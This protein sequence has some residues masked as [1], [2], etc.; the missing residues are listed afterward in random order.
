MNVVAPSPAVARPDHV[1]ESV[2]FDFDL[3]DDA[4]LIADPHQRL[5]EL[6]E[7]A[8]PIF[9]T[10]RRGG[11]WILLGYD[12]NF[13]AARD[14]EVFSSEMI[15][16]SVVSELLA[17][18][19]PGSPR[20]PQAFPINIDPPEHAKYRQPLQGVFSPRTVNAL[21]SEIRELAAELI[22]QFAGNGHC[23]FMSAVAEPLPVRV[24]LNM[25]GLPV[26]QM[27]EYRALVQEQ[28]LLSPDDPECFVTVLKI[29]DTMRDTIAER[30]V[31]PRDDLLSLL[32]KVEI[33]GKPVTQDDVENYG[34]LLFIA[35]LDTVINAIGY[36]IRHLACD[37]ALQ[38]ALREDTSL[39]PIVV[40]EVLRRYAFVNPIRRVNRDTVFQGIPMKEGDHVTLCL[41][42]ANLDSGAFPEAGKFDPHRE[43]KAHI[44]FNAGPHRCLGSHLARLEVQVLLE[45]MLARVP[46]FRL[47][48]DR[49]PTYRGGNILGIE[50]L[51]LALG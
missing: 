1:P 48:A 15:P 40:E 9:W 7:L 39:I 16:Q 21:R 35:G 8:P 3:F 46:A 33:D 11:H 6:Q 10:P 49:S 24:F 32:W 31:N 50:S 14:V 13:A 38:S 30:R 47:D 4:A 2:V 19:P 5:L 22:E 25:L 51:H 43:G 42:A 18:L 12:A 27:G 20:V 44:A 23:E 36:S 37:Q 34:L 29:V 41:P 28:L 26:E 45:E 17:Q